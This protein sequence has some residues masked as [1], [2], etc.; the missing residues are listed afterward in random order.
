MIQKLIIAFLILTIISLSQQRLPLTVVEQAYSSNERLLAEHQMSLEDRYDN[1]AVND[2]FKDNIL[3]TL[4][5]LSGRVHN[6]S[7]INW[8]QVRSSSRYD[9]VLQPG[10]VF[11]FH[12]DVLPQ[13]K[14]RTITTTHAN[15][16]PSQGFKTD[17]FLYGDGVCHLASL[18]TWAAR[19]A[20]L[21]VV[22]PTRHDFAVI[23]E[24]PKIYGTSIVTTAGPS[25]AA[26]T[27]NLYVENT[28]DKP[29]TIVFRNENNSLSV[30]IYQ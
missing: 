19:D 23:P 18:I 22:A 26:E 28:T 24:I 13:Y 16:G 25:L 5:Y 6:A 15:F 8:N 3:L 9:L 20:G 21:T 29:V 14:G 27:Q 7:Q 11:A 30:S 2:V 17:G 10:E 1:K 12:G 4:S